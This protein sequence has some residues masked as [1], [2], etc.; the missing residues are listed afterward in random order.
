MNAG[1][2]SDGYMDT[3]YY[4]Y[5][6]Y[7]LDGRLFYIGKGTRK[8][9]WEISDRNPHWHNVKNK[10]GICIKILLSSLTEEEA[11]IKEREL[12]AEIGLDN[13][14]NIRPGGEGFTSE[15][16]KKL[17]LFLNSIPGYKKK[18]SEGLRRRW[19]D[20]S[21]EQRRAHKQKCKDS[22]INSSE[23]QK[24]KRRHFGE[25]N[26]MWGKKHTTESIEKMRKNRKPFK[27]LSGDLNPSKR[28]EVR[29]KMCE[30]RKKTK[31]IVC[32]V[33]GK[34]V[35]PQNFGR[36]HKNKKCLP[37]VDILVKGAHIT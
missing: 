7:T 4:V 26:G 34:T 11:L 35:D 12:I 15:E 33:C 25:K 18:L 24:Q 5:G 32:S 21:D 16:S 23:E 8:R 37:A 10:Y 30:A 31:P 9:A 20:T 1:D 2:F 36:W 14:T 17:Q 13:L 29:Q 6:H 22:Y 28:P 3:K 27:G 19:A